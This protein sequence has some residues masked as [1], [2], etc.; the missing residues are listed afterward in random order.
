MTQGNGKPS[1]KP[2]HPPQS[3]RPDN[4]PPGPPDDVPPGKPRAPEVPGHRPVG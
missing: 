4:V 1:D 2:A 3:N